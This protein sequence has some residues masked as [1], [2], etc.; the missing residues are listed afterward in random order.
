M[1]ETEEM[2]DKVVENMGRS[3]RSNSTSS[4]S[5]QAWAAYMVILVGVVGGYFLACALDSEGCGDASE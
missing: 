1:E 5:D 2:A 4:D 3:L